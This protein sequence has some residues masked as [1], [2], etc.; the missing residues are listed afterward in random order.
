MAERKRAAADHVSGVIICDSRHWL[1]EEQPEA[2]IAAIR[3]F[4]AA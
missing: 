2:T 1:I 4:L 3:S